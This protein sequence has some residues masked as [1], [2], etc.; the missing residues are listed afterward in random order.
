M[1]IAHIISTFP[2]YK[3]GMGNSVFH[4]VK[5]LARLGHDNTVFTP[6][7]SKEVGEM[8]ETVH[9]KVV[10]LKPF[11]AIGNAAVLPQL[12]WRL[13]GFDIVHLHYPF[14]GTADIVVI[15]KLL[16]LFSAKL[17][18]HYHMDTMA[19]GLKG[20]IFSVYKFF[21]LPIVVRLAEMISCASLDYI[22]HSDLGDYY[23]NHHQKFPVFL[24]SVASG[25]LL[26]CGHSRFLD[27]G[28]VF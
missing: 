7:Y 23:L 20:F 26:P 11:I 8:D 5:E 3:G 12:L 9:L 17:V 6:A 15:A 19:S 14:F 13:R 21:F 16:H 18:I 28:L 4:S 24:S 1:K 22:K 25:S 2:P 27:C 10:R